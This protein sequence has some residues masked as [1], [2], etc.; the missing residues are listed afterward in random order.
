[1]FAR[2][3]NNTVIDLCEDPLTTFHPLIA[4][5]YIIVPDDA[6]I[7]DTFEDGVLTKPEI[8]PETPVITYEKVTPV[9]FM[10]LFTSTERV[11]IKAAR[12]TDPVVDD[13]LDIIEDPRLTHVDLGLKSTQDA[14]DYLETLEL[15]AA[16]RKEEILSNTKV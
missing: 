6:E 14:I 1:M 5:E 9:E 8:T 7:G 16:G 13:F 11:S 10:L 15:I 2:V 12:A 4:K 3:Q